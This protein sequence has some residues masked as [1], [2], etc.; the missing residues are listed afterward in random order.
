MIPLSEAQAQVFS[1][2]TRLPV[3]EVPLADA[4]GLVLA[5]PLAATGPIP[6][7]ANTAVDGFAVRAADTAGATPDSPV[8]LEIVANL[9]CGQA[10]STPVGPGEAIRIMTGAPIPDGCD[11]IV[12]VEDTSLDGTATSNGDKLGGVLIGKAARLGDAIRPAGGDLAEGDLAF[13]AG[14]VLGPA[15]LGVCSSLGHATIPVYRRARVAVMSTGDE[16]VPPGEPLGIGQIRDSNRPMLLSLV[17]Q[18]GAEVVDLG[19]AKDD[20]A[21]IRERVEH[22]MATCDVLVTS[23]GVSMGDYD[24]V[25]LALDRLGKLTWFQ[26][27][28]K[29]AK[30]LAFGSFDGRLVFGLPGNPVSSHVSFELFARPAILQMM[31]HERPFRPV[32][33]GVAE[34]DM[35][36]SSDGKIHLDRVRVTRDGDRL[37]AARAGSQASNVLS[38]MALSNALALLPDGT[39]VAAGETVDLMMI[40]LPAG[41]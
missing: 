40:D 27:A 32:L 21:Y 9:A 24:Y 4:L 10:P 41:Y 28:I 34:H 13:P 26:V 15:H 7:F 6:P 16:L 36:R 14:T 18:A 35:R 12:M 29:P 1:A 31:G 8:R 30:P 11:A 23:G 38:A 3:V 20:E 17:A 25:K 33:R 22:A 5:E 19:V 2:V 39:G 37:T